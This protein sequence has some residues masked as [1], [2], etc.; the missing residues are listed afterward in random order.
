MTHEV[1]IMDANVRAGF[2]VDGGAMRFYY[3]GPAVDHGRLEEEMKQQADA[4][5]SE[6]V[7]NLENKIRG[8]LLPSRL[9][10]LLGE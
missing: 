3:T 1:T 10:E 8:L 6:V 2:R 4:I 7:I 9:E 5:F